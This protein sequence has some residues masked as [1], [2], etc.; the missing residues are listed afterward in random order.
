MGLVSPNILKQILDR[1]KVKQLFLDAGYTL[2]G[3]GV[4]VHCQ[5][6][7]HVEIVKIIPLALIDAL[8][9]LPCE[10]QLANEQT[11]EKVLSEK[12]LTRT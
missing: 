1:T 5:D 12:D 6:I 3:A 10:Q 2:A 8:C 7:R 9:E 4:A 11:L